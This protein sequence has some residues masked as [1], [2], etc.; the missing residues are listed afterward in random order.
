MTAPTPAIPSF[1]DGT[2]VHQTDLNAL[3]SNLTNI[4][5][6]LLGGFRT[7]P[8][9]AVI[10]QNNAQTIASGAS[11]AAFVLDTAVLNTNNMW[12]PSV[13]SQITIQTAGT[14]LVLFHV[15]WGAAFTG[16]RFCGVTLNGTTI[17]TNYLA[18]APYYDPSLVSGASTLCAAVYPLSIGA[19][20]YPLAGQGSGVNQAT[21][22]GASLNSFMSVTRIS[23]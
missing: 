19:E 12:T 14:Y 13:P 20:L 23:D 18:N 5:S 16:Y 21:A 15:E 8:P 4:Y 10:Q 2:V 6:Y 3:A 7:Q 11:G 22:T 1:V 17:P 9:I